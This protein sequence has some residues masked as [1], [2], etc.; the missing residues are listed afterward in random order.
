[1]NPDEGAALLEAALFCPA[2]PEVLLP[3]AWPKLQPDP[4]TGLFDPP[5]NK[6]LPPPPPPKSELPPAAFVL[7]NG[8]A[9]DDAGGLTLDPNNPPADVE[10][11]VFV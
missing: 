5:P 7:P 1:M 9:A 2:C 11:E 6:L 3:C 10:A 8:F 4:P